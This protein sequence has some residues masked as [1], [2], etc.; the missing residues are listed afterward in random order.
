MRKI[1]HI[2]HFVRSTIILIMVCYFGLIAVLNLSFIQRQ[3]SAIAA[4]E[5]EKIMKTE[6][7][8][9][10]IDL[11]LLNRIIIQNVTLK[12]REKHEM[13]KISRLSAKIDI[14]PL[15]HGKIRISSVQ[16]FGLNARLNRKTPDSPTNFQ[17]VLNAFASKDTVKK[18]TNIDLRINSVLIR[19]G[20]IYYDILSE[21][22]TPDRFNAKHIGIQNISATVSLKA[23]TKDSVNAQIRRMSFNEDSGFKLKKLAVK[24]IATPRLLTV[25]DL[26]I[27]L[28]NTALAIDSLTATYDS[29]PQFP[30]LDKG[31][32]YQMKL[33]ASITPA[34]IA[35]FVPALKHFDSPIDFRLALEGKGNQTRCTDIYVSGNKQTLLLKAQ[36][37]VN[38]WNRK[39][40]LYLFGQVSQLDADAQGLAWLFHNLTGKESTPSAVK[41]LGDVHFNGDVSGYLHQL[42]THGTLTSEAGTIQA[43]VTMHR[44]KDASYRSYSGKIISTQLNLGTL[45]GQEQTLG[46]TSF[47]IELQGLRYKDGKPESYIKGTISSLAYKQY[48]YHN[49]LL[50]GQYTPGGF[51]GKISMNDPN[52]EIE[53]NGH[54]ATQQPVPDFNLRASINRFCPN[55]LN[56]TKKYADTDFSLNLLADFSGNSIDDIQG[57]IS[58]DSIRMHSP[59]EEKCYSLDHFI[60]QAG[61]TGTNNEKQI[62][63]RSPFLNGKVEGHYSYR[64]LP[65]SIL[66]T[67]HRYLPSLLASGKE[68]PASDNN[69][70]FQ[71]QMDDAEFLSKVADIPLQ[72][73]MPVSLQGYFDDNRTRI[74]VRAYAPEFTYKGAYYEAGTFLCDNT[75]EGLQCQLRANKRMKKGSMVNLAVNALAKEDQLKATVNWGNNTAD[76]FSGM[77]GATASFEKPESGEK[78]STRIDIQP[79]Q[80]VL[81]DSI[82][83]IHPSEV[84][85]DQ[86]I[87]DVRNFLFE[88]QDQYVRANGRIGKTE[89]D[90]CT[91]DLSNI[92]LQYIMDI[93]QFHAVKF[94]GLI[95]GRVHLHHVL[96]KPVM[97]A[98]LDVKNFS[99]N[100]ALL[101]RGDIKAAWDNEL[102]GIRLLADIRE[103]KQYSTYVDGYI[104]PKEKGLD[105]HIR[106]GGTNLAFLQPFIDGIFTNMQGRVFGNVRLFGPF[107]GLDLEG[108]AQAD[109]SMK[110][111][112]LN[113]A[114]KVHADSVHIRSGHFGFDNV[115]IADMEGH[116]GTVNG[117]LDHR[118]LKHLT[119]NFRFNTNNMLV[120]HTEKETPE[121]PFY[122]TIY[123]TGEV[124]LRGGNNA[125]NVDGTLRTDPRTSFTYVTATATEATS[126][127]FIE[128]VDRTPK[129]QQE[130]IYTEVYHPLNVVKEEEE[131]DTP[132]DMHLNFQIEA[133]PDATMRIVM[134]P[135]AG[136]NISANGSGNLRINFYNKG[137]FLIF[138]NYNIEE[139]IYK[140]S[141]QNV[142]RKDFVLQS[143]GTVSFNGNPRQANLNVQA[144]Y[145]VNSA[146]L[147]DLVAD[148]SSTK[149][150]VRVNCLL[151]L[152]GNLTSPTLKFDLDLPTVSDEDRELV[153]SLTST[154]EQMNTQIIYLLGIG[155]FY[156]YDYNNNAN[157]SDATSSLAFSTLSGQLNNMLSQVIDSQNWNVGTNLS[158]GENGWTDVEA[159]AILSGRLLNNRLI[160]NGNFGYRDNALQNTNFVGDFEAM[161]MLTKNGEFRLKGYNE[162]NDRYFTKSTL[163]TQGIGLMYKKDFDNWRE[164]FD[165]ILLRRRKRQKP[166][167]EQPAAQQKRNQETKL[168]D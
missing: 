163:T 70:R 37:M 10:N 84:I 69:F 11:G 12:D 113:T 76:T 148:A 35:M 93:I 9:G 90:S 75:E 33:N 92:N 134:D 97:N 139:G 128:F 18:E 156:T 45:L 114:F 112:I 43:N 102:G 19:R 107:A 36:G 46:N 23:L 41:R 74:Q 2:K 138:G 96:D 6:V 165:W 115:Q 133:T 125:L 135:V 27:Q 32:A 13:L 3:L 108:S 86:G 104:S 20:Q 141:M 153:R 154:E 118:K 137:D 50:D 4:S 5:L 42:T 72:L 143:G 95:T 160:I 66:K 31:T 124:L 99:L 29:V 60:I 85:I 67:V 21:P 152:S 65:V 87:I 68:M 111:D 83:T 157:Q 98:R 89:T 121:F 161:W 77:I 24:M 22:E 14:T 78:L 54:I 55:K 162:T 100:D 164:L 136:D 71:L 129:R 149:G 109:A 57:K 140:M 91:V 94:N 59:E 8:I 26:E 73:A 7:S 119:Y 150:T 1:I 56:L 34:D 15:L 61:T 103:N 147:N 145:T 166:T 106:A 44:L 64:T 146:S 105:L 144:V 126:N 117:S 38:H 122:G 39:E 17:F 127:Q 158:T 131:D 159:E 132:L 168:T 80:I 120:F 101:G 130:H 167:E 110:V 82:W 116:T 30:K 81:N 28:P 79:S 142:I 53:I 16:L 51:D 88:H 25:S 47:D 40:D 48:E 63:I 123:T 49:I 155:K 151:N 62:E 58:I 52:G